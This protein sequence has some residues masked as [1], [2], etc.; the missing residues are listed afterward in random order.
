[1]RKRDAVEKLVGPLSME[2]WVAL[3]EAM[4]ETTHVDL[5][6]PTGCIQVFAEPE[7]TRLEQIAVRVC[8]GIVALMVVAISP[9]FVLAL[10][11]YLLGRA[12]SPLAERIGR[13]SE[14]E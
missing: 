10:P 1:M 12:V 11:L 5:P 2:K 9:L 13:W 8:R 6:P 4:D 7:K 14:G 3:L